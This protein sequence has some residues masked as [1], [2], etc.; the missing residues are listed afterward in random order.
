MEDEGCPRFHLTEHTDIDKQNI[1]LI[2]LVL[3]PGPRGRRQPRVLAA[4]SRHFRKQ[5]AASA[6]PQPA[7]P[8]G[9]AAAGP[10]HLRLGLARSRRGLQRLCDGPGHRPLLRRQGDDDIR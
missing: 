9:A 4:D 5:S 8:G 3:S 2:D 7:R 10:R 6:P 1:L